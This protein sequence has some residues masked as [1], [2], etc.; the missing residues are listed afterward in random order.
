M[1]FSKAGE[2]GVSSKYGSVCAKYLQS[3][4]V[5]KGVNTEKVKSK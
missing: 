2:I 1:T 4:H 3:L 5:K